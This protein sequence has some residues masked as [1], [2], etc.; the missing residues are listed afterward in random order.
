M[1][2]QNINQINESNKNKRY[3][4]DIIKDFFIADKEKNK[5]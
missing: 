4:V 1:K 3:A 5:I 2:Q